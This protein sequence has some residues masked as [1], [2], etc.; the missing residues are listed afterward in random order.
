MAG[1][2]E[3]LEQAARASACSALSVSDF[4]DELLDA[5]NRPLPLL[6]QL[7][8]YTDSAREFYRD[9]ICP[10]PSENP[11]GPSL[12]PAQGGPA[13]PG[14]CPVTYTWFW[15]VES[16][17]NIGGQPPGAPRGP[18]TNVGP[19][20]DFFE[21]GGALRMQVEGGASSVLLAFGGTVAINQPSRVNVTRNDGQ[22]DECP[23]EPGFQPSQPP[24]TEAPVTYDDPAGNPITISPRFSFEP[25][26]VGPTNNFNLPF[27]LSYNNFAI[28]GVVN[29]N[30]GGVSF[31]FGGGSGVDND[32][33]L[34]SATEN[35]PPPDPEG[36]PDPQEDE[37]ITGVVVTTTAI[38]PDANITILQNQDGPN[39]HFPDLGLVTFR[40]KIGGSFV[41]SEPKRVQIRQQVVNVDWPEGAVAVSVA[42]R[43]GVTLTSEVVYA[44]VPLP[45]E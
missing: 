38:A 11:Y 29:L 7:D 14:Q 22:P 17:Q 43:V 26:I 36:E 18:F 32:C 42:A 4:L 13:E 16:T 3:T 2:R 44:K 34:P 31:N 5:P 28:K 20:G 33:C 19:L 41:W 37:V 9:I 10:S 6:G 12:P 35:P 24:F 30:L 45:G 23:G 25:V 21:A 15:T 39:F 40:I 8:D 1:L 27:N